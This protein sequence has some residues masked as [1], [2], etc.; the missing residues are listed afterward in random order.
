MLN[1]LQLT[2]VISHHHDMNVSTRKNGRCIDYI[3]ASHELANNIHQCGA[4]LYN[5]IVDSDHRPLFIDFCTDFLFGNLPNL[6]THP[7]R[8]IYSD[9]PSACRKYIA[10]LADYFQ[11]HN[12]L[13]RAGKLDKWTN[14]HGLTPRLVELWE[15]LDEDITRSCLA[16]E[17]HCGRCHTAPWS[18]KLHQAHLLVLFWKTA[19]YYLKYS[20]DPNPALAPILEKLQDKPAFNNDLAFAKGQLRSSAKELYKI[21][22]NAAVHRQRHLEERARLAASASDSSTESILRRIIQAENTK[23]AYAKLRYYLKPNQSGPIGEIDVLEADGYTVH[24]SNPIEVF[25]RIIERDKLHYS[26]A[27]GTPFTE[28]PFAS[29]FNLAGNTPAINAFL[30]SGQLP[31][32]LLSS[33]PVYPE[34]IKLINEMRPPPLRLPIIDITITADD[35]RIFFK[36]WK[37]STTTSDRRHLGHWKALTCE[38]PADD[39]LHTHADDIIQVFIR[40]LNLATKKGYAWRRWLRIISAKIPKREGILLLDKLRTIHLFEPDFNWILGLL[41]GKRMLQSAD[42]NGLL[43]DNQYGSRPGR[44]AIGAVL[45]KLLSYEICRLTRSSMASFDND[46]KSCYDCIVISFAMTLC[47]RLG[48]PASACI[49]A[50]LCLQNAKYFIKTKFGISESFYSSTAEH[51]T[52]G[53]GQGS[54]MGPVLWLIISCLLFAAMAR[55]CQ[56]AHF[57]NPSQTVE[58]RRTGD[59]FVDDV[60]N[61]CNFGFPASLN[62]MSNPTSLASRLQA[63]A[64][65]WERL[66]WSTGGAL[67]LS[68]CFYYLLVWRFKKDGSPYFLL[69]PDLHCT[70]QLTSGTNRTPHIIEHKA[71]SEAHRT[72]GVWISPTGDTSP[73]F[74]HC[75]SR[76]SQICRG[77]NNQHLTKTQAY[78]AYRHIWLPSVGYPLACSHLSITQLS[79]IDR[80]AMQAFL[81]KLGFARTF[82]RSVIYGPLSLGGYGLRS[83]QAHQGIEQTILF[84]QHFRLQDSPGR[85]LRIALDWYQLVCGVDFPVLSAPGIALPHAPPGWLSSLRSFLSACHGRF[86]FLTD[87]IR[88]PKGYR[89]NDCN[90]MRA[91]LTLHLKPRQLRSLNLC[92]LYLQVEYLSELCSLQGTYILPSVWRGCRPPSRSTLQWPLQP[93][94]QSWS[95]WRHSL[96][97]LFLRNKFPPPRPSASDLVLQVPLGE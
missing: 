21:R 82:P 33:T 26:Q 72:L 2:D 46:A 58:L 96:A 27:Q 87:Y 45:L 89:H 18:P 86:L 16:A 50:A 94:P 51:P 60:T 61:I 73:Q 49:M 14:S 71:A 22:N 19:I 36:K 90:I 78:M 77:I 47:Q 12:I 83:I 37:E 8:G 68:K 1:E 92:R 31:P 15:K 75:N 88:V 66:L 25:Q 43:H 52:H 67:E 42:R 41:F 62:L 13:T 81:P 55:L 4:E 95:L 7:K 56:G 80:S 6:Y 44:H 40:Q 20:Q 85:L 34:T 24:V 28:E 91:F 29:L 84:L 64:Q 17:K 97:T 23:A 30:R 53:P 76:N 5:T 11:K 59:G 39:P 65:T 48:M 9:D 3:F 54:R 93:R 74:L 63:E 35:Y 70:V 69:P 79:T 38:L 10:T 32:D 57:S